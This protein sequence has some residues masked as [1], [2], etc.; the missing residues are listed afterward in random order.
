MKKI[1][2]LL[3][4]ASMLSGVLPAS[5]AK[6]TFTDIA[7]PK[8]S[9]AREYIEE[10]AEQGY[11]AGYEDDTYRPDNK[12][13]RL[14]TIVLF[15]RA[16]GS[17]REENEEVLEIAKEQYGDT[18]EDLGL[19]F[20]E[21]EIAF[22]LYRG[23]LSDE[24]L[25]T[26]L[27]K[28]K[29]SQPMPRQEA[30]AI[31]TKA[32]CAEE[33]AKAEVLTDME[34]TDAKE[35][36]SK[37]SQYVFYVSEAGIMN[38]MEDNSFAPKASVLRSQI[39]AM[40]YRAVDKINLYVEKA[41]V[42]ELDTG[43]NNITI[44]AAEGEEIPMGYTDYTKFYIDDEL[45]AERYMS[46][47]TEARLTYI[48]NELVYVD[49]LE[50]VVDKTLKG[51][52]QGYVSKNG[53][54]IVTIKETASDET[55]EYELSD[56]ARFYDEKGATSGINSF[57]SGYYVELDVTDDKIIRITNIKKDKTILNAVIESVGIDDEMYITI[58]HDDEEYNG[59]KFI[60]G[61]DVV[62]YKNN[63]REDLSKLYKGDRVEIT[64]EYEIPVKIKA[65]SDSKMYEGVIS[66]VVISS[67]PV[68]KVKINGEIKEYDILPDV[69][70]TVSGEAGSIYDL[71]VGDS[72]KI[73]TESGTVMTI[74]TVA[75]AVTS[76]PV[77]GVIEAVNT[78]RGFIKV[79]GETIFC[80]DTTTT[81]ISS[82]GSDKFMKDLKE[83]LTVSIRGSMQNGAYTAALIII[84]D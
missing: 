10:M 19:N 66:E 21:D 68:L 7:D 33:V 5:A 26:Y 63:D 69:K 43:K 81:I 72:V 58:S 82:N 76:N 45:S 25:D 65:V 77:T 2:G 84:E 59:K 56:Y 8:Y 51:V 62:V 79:N 14:E 37:Y 3:L 74:S 78:S 61:E 30:C 53:H 49:M 71:R 83:G 20:G 18:V 80:K 40:L 12:V 34:Y 57:K 13:T 23:A 28:K 35:I 11:I 75:A 39:A 50:V 46:V 29:A 17:N 27:S 38:G 67:S 22:M 36:D 32:M 70:V 73:T 54:T 55:Y 41:L 16:M 52:F 4:A 60:L 15:A 44:K 42:T 9:W 64:M 31:I 6:T 47:N 48:N 1:F 24:D